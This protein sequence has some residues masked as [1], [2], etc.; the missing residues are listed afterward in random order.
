MEPTGGQ[1]DRK[2]S[3]YVEGTPDSDIE[4]TERSAS[5][6]HNSTNSRRLRR[7]T[8]IERVVESG[9]PRFRL[10]LPSD[11]AVLATVHLLFRMAGCRVK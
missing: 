4:V 2:D 3:G 7:V 10:I 5:R 9:F 11:V 8:H 6:V 1:F